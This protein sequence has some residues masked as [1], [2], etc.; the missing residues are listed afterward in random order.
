MQKDAKQKI[1]DTHSENWMINKAVHYNQWANL[2]P[3]EFA[4]SPTDY[5]GRPC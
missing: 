1:A 4:G 3:K 2:Q 5:S